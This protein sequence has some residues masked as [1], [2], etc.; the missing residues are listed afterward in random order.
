MS[1]AATRRSPSQ[2]RGR[3][4]KPRRRPQKS[5]AKRASILD[6]T[7]AALPVSE[8]TLHRIIAWAIFLGV[9]ALAI[10]GAT[11]LRLP[12]A[13]YVSAAEGLGKMGLRVD[14]IEVKGLHRMDRMS[15]Y[16]MALDQQSQAMPL[17]NLSEV[18]NRLLNYGWVEDARVS[19][20]L[21][22]KLVIDIVERKPAAIWQYDGQ[23]MLVD[24]K[25]VLLQPVS[26]DKMPDL[27]L[28]IGDGANAQAPD[29]QK[30]MEAAP[31]L[32]PRVKAA[33]WIGNRRWDLTFNTGEKLELPEGLAVAQRMLAKFA[34]L[35]G[36]EGLLGKGYLYF[37]MRDPT[38]LVVRMPG[39]AIRTIPNGA[40]TPESDNKTG[41]TG[42]ASQSGGADA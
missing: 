34:A 35:D 9:A 30:L 10:A 5:R 3:T 27:P 39:D 7:V 41:D 18:R 14:Q 1:R 42:N 36:M 4:V 32:K 22:D 20:R 13:A 12:Q 25:G 29:Y 15:V 33:T 8:H 19:R 2:Q 16:A 37:D 28:L 17:V 21:P 26:P 31:A 11:W 6:R 24:A 23:L 38:R 40:K